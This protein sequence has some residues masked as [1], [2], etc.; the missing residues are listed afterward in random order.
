[1]ENEDFEIDKYESSCSCHI[2]APCEVCI[3]NSEDEKDKIIEE[4][5]NEFN[6]VCNENEIENLKMN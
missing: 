6:L 5:K 2:S 4:T 3:N 1:M